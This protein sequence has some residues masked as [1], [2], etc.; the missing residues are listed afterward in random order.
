MGD[1]PSIFARP[2]PAQ[3]WAWMPAFA[4]LCALVMLLAGAPAADSAGGEP[5]PDSRPTPAPRQPLERAAAVD[6]STAELSLSRPYLLAGRPGQRLEVDADLRARAAKSGR[7]TVQLRRIRRADPRHAGVTLG[8]E[9]V[10]RARR[11]V[12]GGRL[13]VTLRGLAPQPG[14][15]RLAVRKG[16]RTLA[17][18]R[19]EVLSQGRLPIAAGAADSVTTEPTASAAAGG[20]TDRRLRAQRAV[21]VN[22]SLGYKPGSQA[23]SA[24]AVKTDDPSRAIAATNDAGD[25]PLAKISSDSLRLGSFS[26]ERLP[27]STRL[28]NGSSL[29]VEAC[30]DPAVAADSTGNLWMAATS[31]QG[32][33]RILLAR[34]GAGSNSFGSHSAGLPTEPGTTSQQKP[35]LA[36]DDG[37]TIAAAWIETG[38]GV[39]NV[40]V[41]LCDLSAG[42]SDCDDPANW[43]APAPITGS[44]GLYS[45]P[46]LGFAPNGDLYAVWWDAGSDNA[47]EI[48]RCEDGESCSSAASWNEQSTVEELD[49]FDDDGSGDAD[50]LPLFCPI[51][52]APGGLVNPSPSVEVGPAGN[53]FVAFSDLRDNPD[54]ASPSRCTASGSDKT[55]DSF[56]AAGLAP[57]DFPAAGSGVRLSNDGALDVNDHFLPALSVDPSSGVVEAG[58]YTTALNASGQFARRM[59]TASADVGLSWSE[60][61]QTATADSRFS[62]TNSDGVDYG[63][64]QGADSAEGTFRPAWTDGRPIQGRDPELYALAPQVETQI[65][66]APA[67]TVPDA[68]AIFVFSSPAPRTDCSIDGAPFVSCR[69]PY[70]VGPLPNGSHNLRVRSTDSVGNVA[71]LSDASASWTVSDLD[72]PETTI[73][74]APKPKVKKKRPVIDFIADEEAAKFSCRYDREEWRSCKPPKRGRV[75]LGKHRFQVRAI[76]I[77]GNEDPTAAAVKFKRVEKCKK[78]KRRKGLC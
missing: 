53:V 10:A 65:T 48:A 63:D 7:L 26:T 13:G 23:S 39:Q 62:G 15:H 38:G 25:P 69:S 67:G 72:P 35:A 6:P 16:R 3:R 24:V 4:A 29:A 21:E 32:G 44:S 9:L 50:P 55:F 47:I 59:Y 51:I 30:C 60:P 1:R 22:Q 76:D 73:V 71:D 14:P 17:T 66:E 54:A 58:F 46:D 74:N 75:S 36:V 61:E 49:S 8:G 70:T 68:K 5:R 40:V 57:N 12:D 45:M 42:A 37:R 28:Q 31:T 41:S 33:G 19:I 52:A 2:L 64:R 56:V 34:A 11:S 77:G 27:G 20:E 43:S 18:T 78:K